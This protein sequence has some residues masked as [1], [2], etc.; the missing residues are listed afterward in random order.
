MDWTSDFLIWKF[1]AHVH[2]WG[3]WCGSYH[4]ILKNFISRFIYW[5]VKHSFELTI[6]V[7]F[8]CWY[9]IFFDALQILTSWERHRIKRNIFKNHIANIKMDYVL[10]FVMLREAFSYRFAR[11]F[12]FFGKVWGVFIPTHKECSIHF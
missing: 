5:G 6:S 8:S 4:F 1:M 3:C 12:L 7:F 10:K 11:L 2:P 9:T